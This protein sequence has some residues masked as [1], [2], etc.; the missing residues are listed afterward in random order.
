[1]ADVINIELTLLDDG[2]IAGNGGWA[3]T[4][5]GM[6]YP[7]RWTLPPGKDFDDQVAYDDLVVAARSGGCL[8]IDGDTVTI[9]PRPWRD[10]L[11]EWLD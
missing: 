9:D 8:R 3:T 4:D 11:A 2:S 7:V 6:H 1:M 5:E 10:R